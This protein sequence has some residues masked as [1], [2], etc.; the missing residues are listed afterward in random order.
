MSPRL[1]SRW[2]GSSLSGAGVSPAESAGLNLAHRESLLDF[3]VRHE[4]G[5]AFCNNVNEM[6]ADRVAKLLEQKNPI[7]CKAKVE[8]NPHQQPLKPFSP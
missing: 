6:D 5:H 2:V 3:A 4:L 8:A 7:S 1:D